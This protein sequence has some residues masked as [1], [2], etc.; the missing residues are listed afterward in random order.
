MP[1]VA[2]NGFETYYEDEGEGMPIVLLH[3]A[4]SDH[5]LWSHVVKELRDSYRLIRYDARDHGKSGTPTTD[6]TVPDLTE[7][8]QTI[9]DTLDLSAPLICGLSIGGYIAQQHAVTYP[10]TARGYV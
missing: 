9:I 2:V 8:L 1:T 6:Y 7:D 4:T 10:E 3:G 5:Q